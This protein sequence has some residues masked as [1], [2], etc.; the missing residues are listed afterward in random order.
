MS[1][2]DPLLGPPELK[3]SF[4]GR[5]LGDADA[6][7]GGDGLLVGGGVIVVVGVGLLVFLLGKAEHTPQ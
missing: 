5:G 1:G 4:G 7:L 3:R 2:T 6:L